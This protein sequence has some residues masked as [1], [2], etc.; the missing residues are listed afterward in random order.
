MKFKVAVIA[1][2]VAILGV[3]TAGT[4]L[5][6]QEAREQTK[7]ALRTTEI[8]ALQADLEAYTSILERHDWNMDYWIASQAEDS[9]NRIQDIFEELRIE[10][11]VGYGIDHSVGYQSIVED[12]KSK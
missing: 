1:I 3:T 5:V 7:I 9:I 10:G 12:L 11:K 2:L 6:V 8:I 4:V